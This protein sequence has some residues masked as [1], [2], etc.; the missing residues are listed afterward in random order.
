MSRTAAASRGK[1]AA[2]ESSTAWITRLSII[3]RVAGMMP[4]RMM[5]ETV[6]F[7]GLD[8]VEHGEHRAH[9]L[10]RRHE[11]E[12]GLRADAERPLAA[13]EQPDEVVPGQVRRLSAEPHH[14][15]V[16]E[17]DSQPADVIARDAVLEAVGPA[18]PLGH[19]APD[20]TGLPAGRVRRIEVAARR[21][22]CAHRRVVD[23]GLDL[24]DTIVR[25]EAEVAVHLRE[26]D[27]EGVLE[28]DRPAGEVRAAATWDHGEAMPARDTHG[29]RDFL[30]AVREDDRR[31]ERLIE[32]GI[33]GEREQ[34]H[35]FREHA[36]LA[37]QLAELP[38]RLS[39]ER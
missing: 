18:G 25:G 16:G 10:R 22:G 34:M 9:R 30:R 39:A 14:R 26:L 33:V 29:T 24:D 8:G 36:L 11:L 12:A 3:S 13:D 6:S 19:V 7:R 20:G 21:R 38:V 2:S 32:K 28:R 37:E 31:G 17:D 23:A 35:A 27:D 1:P 4:A 5:A 15:A